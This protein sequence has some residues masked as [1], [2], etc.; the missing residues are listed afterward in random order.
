MNYL[1]FTEFEMIMLF[2]ATSWYFGPIN[3]DDGENK[4]GEKE[5]TK[6]SE[7]IIGGNIIIYLIQTEKGVT[8]RYIGLISKYIIDLARVF[9]LINSKFQVFYLKY[10]DNSITPENNIILAFKIN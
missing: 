3:L 8:K 4:K 5:K 9:H 1:G 10:C 6:I 7:E 2:K